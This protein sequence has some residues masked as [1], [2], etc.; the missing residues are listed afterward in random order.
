MSRQRSRGWCFTYHLT[1][2]LKE[3]QI[4]Y[5]EWMDSLPEKLT[6][7]D[8]HWSIWQIELC[9]ESKRYHVQGAAYFY[10]PLTFK[11]CK[12]WLGGDHVHISKM[13]GT[14]QDQINYCHDKKKQPPDWS[15]QVEAGKRPESNGEQGKRT[16]LWEVKVRT[17]N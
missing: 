13:K 4:M 10:E 14:I 7:D 11:N 17:A 8:R 3:S 1:T 15:E 16:D 12:K 6:E 5:M 2:D 9:P